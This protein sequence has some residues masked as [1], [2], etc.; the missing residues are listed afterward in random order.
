MEYK[1]AEIAEELHIDTRAITNAIQ[2][3]LPARKES[4]HYWIDGMQ[5]IE[6]VK[7]EK[8][9]KE[10]KPNNEFYCIPC[11]KNMLVTAEIIYSDKKVPMLYSICPVCN[12]AVRKFTTKRNG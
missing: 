2:R 7:D 12:R 4:G 9:V 10:V 8:P 3:G 1:P 5:F 11:K 6:W